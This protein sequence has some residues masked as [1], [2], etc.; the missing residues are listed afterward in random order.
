MAV[1]I[2]Q[3]RASERH[4]HCRTSHNHL[5]LFILRFSQEFLSKP[6]M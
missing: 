6:Y 2:G 3:T 4:D 5:F 1:L